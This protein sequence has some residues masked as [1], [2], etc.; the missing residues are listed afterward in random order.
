MSKNTG[1][2]TLKINGVDRPFQ[3]FSTRQ[4]DQFCAT[5]GVELDDYWTAMS[6]LSDGSTL[7]NAKIMMVFLWSALYAGA[8]KATRKCDFTFDDV[9]DWF[10]DAEEDEAT[11]L[12]KPLTLLSEM[13]NAKKKELETALEISKQ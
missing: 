5:L 4:T 2:G 1:T 8:M 3:V 7:T 11:E 9:I 12:L 10:E 13:L 6:K